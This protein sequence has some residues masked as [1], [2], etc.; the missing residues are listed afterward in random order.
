MV[1][2]ELLGRVRQRT[3]SLALENYFEL[4]AE[5]PGRAGMEAEKPCNRWPGLEVAGMGKRKE[6]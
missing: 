1:N 3:N 2:R 5:G 6:T 4:C